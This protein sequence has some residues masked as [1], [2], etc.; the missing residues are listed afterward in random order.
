MD[1]DTLMEAAPVEK[2]GS[3]D[4]EEVA[5]RD[6]AEVSTER[7]VRMGSLANGALCTAPAVEEELK[8]ARGAP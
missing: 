3:K 6:D 2:M 1:D 8:A 5:A 4:I 7:V